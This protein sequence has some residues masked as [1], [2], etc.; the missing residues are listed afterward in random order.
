MAEPLTQLGAI[1]PPTRAVAV[2]GVVHAHVVAAADLLRA[3]LAEPW[4][5]SSLAV[6]SIFH[7]LSS[8]GPLTPWNSK[9]RSASVCR[10]GGSWPMRVLLRTGGPDLNLGDLVA[11]PA[12]K[13]IRLVYA[14]PSAPAS[15]HGGTAPAEV[16][17]TL[18]GWRRPRSGRPT[19]PAM[20]R[21]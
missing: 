15:P 13:T 7:A 16:G 18:A 12:G 5:L 2:R 10:L 17:R 19:R 8:C 1:E 21:C 4:T 20:R 6:K 11:I 9:R 14:A 3:Q